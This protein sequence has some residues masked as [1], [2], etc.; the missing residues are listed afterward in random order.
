[1]AVGCDK[2]GDA[3]LFYFYYRKQKKVQN[4]LLAF[5]R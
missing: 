5:Q 1:M 3:A 2:R 4:L